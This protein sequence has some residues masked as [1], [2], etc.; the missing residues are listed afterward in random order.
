MG[1]ALDTG[2]SVTGKVQEADGEV[3]YEIVAEKADLGT[4]ADA[5]QLMRNKEA[6]KGKALAVAHVK[7]THSS[8]PNLTAGSRT[9]GGTEICTD[10]GR[11]A[12]CI[13]SPEADTEGC[14]DQYDISSWKQGESH[15]FCGAYLVPPDTKSVEVHWSEEGGEPYIWKFAVKQEAA[16]ARAPVHALGAPLPSKGR[17]QRRTARS[18]TGGPVSP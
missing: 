8:G 6:A 14:E 2:E 13:G 7:F 5:R 4:E 9:Y 12:T 1:A 10:G 3:T 11:S 15:V 18:G 16:P 17:P